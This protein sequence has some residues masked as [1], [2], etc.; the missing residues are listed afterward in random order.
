MQIV[1]I[2]YKPDTQATLLA[3]FSFLLLTL[4]IICLAVSDNTRLTGLAAKSHHY[5]TISY[6]LIASLF[7]LFTA[8]GLLSTYKSY[9]SNGELILTETMISASDGRTT[10][11]ILYSEIR[12]M[13]AHISTGQRI[14]NIAYGDEQS[15]TIAESLLP[16]RKIFEELVKTI[17]IKV[18]GG[19]TV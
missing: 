9:T 11:T 1:R 15:F 7:L 18:E 8:F 2:P 5:A 6:W 10:I 12:R 4:L 13:T 19:F 16:S 17:T 3:S 14:L